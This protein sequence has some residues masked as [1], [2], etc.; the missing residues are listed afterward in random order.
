MT[1]SIWPLRNGRPT[2]QIELPLPDG[3]TVARTL[4]ADTGA[5][6]T[7]SEFE[8]VLDEEDCLLGGAFPCDPIQLRGAYAGTFPVYLLS[9]RVPGI[10]EDHDVRAVAVEKTPAG[11][12]GI[13]CFR[14]LNRFSFGNF[15]NREQFGI[16]TM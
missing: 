13:A 1:R 16:E 8:L 4:L 15:G 7:R 14:F 10:P 3:K 12:D 9:I 5:G 11:L 2:I 6:T